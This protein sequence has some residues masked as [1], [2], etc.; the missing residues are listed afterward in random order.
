MSTTFTATSDRIFAIVNDGITTGLSVPT[1]LPN[2]PFQVPDPRGAWC[3]LSIDWTSA[4]DEI[5]GRARVRGFVVVSVFV[6]IATG[7]RS[8]LALSEQIR[9]V[10]RSGDGSSL[11]I[12]EVRIQPVQSD[13][14]SGWFQ[15]NVRAAFFADE[16]S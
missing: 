6:P 1:A 10:L 13:G 7:Y 2:I 12:E 5:I 3:R 4:T 16:V 11:V 8:G 9:D 15:F 14:S